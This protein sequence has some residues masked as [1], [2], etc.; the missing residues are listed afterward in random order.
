M[1][2]DTLKKKV[3]DVI[4]AKSDAI[5]KIGE[6]V[7]D[8]PEMGYREEKT[9]KLVRDTFDELGISYTYPVA[10]TGVKGKL[11]GKES[12]YNVCIMSEEDCIK[13]AENPHS[14][15]DGNSHACG[16]HAQIAAMLGAAIGIKES[17]VMDELYGDIT[18]MATPAEE[19]IELDYR[20]LLKDEG[21][22]Q[23]Y[24]GKQQLIYEGAF[25]DVDMAMMIHAQGND[26]GSKFYAKGY[27][28]GFMAST[29]TFKGKAV[30]ASTPFDGVNALNAASLAILGV[31]SN[32]E[33]F[34][35]EDRIRIH[36]IITKGGDVVNAVP[37]E[38][39]VDTYV[40][41]ASLDAINK[42]FDALIRACN[43]AAQMVGATVEFLNVPGYLPLKESEELSA[44]M[45][46]NAKAILGEDKIIYGKEITGSTD[47]GDLSSILPTIQPSISGFSG[48]LHSKEFDTV[49]K[50][51]AYITSA[52]LLAATAIDL[53]FDGAKG[54]KAVVDNF[55][56][57][58]SKE[59]YLEYLG[60]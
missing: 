42:G 4:D 32:R 12:R 25:D 52:K 45:E 21:K 17:G 56:G 13:C 60:K 55:K 3:F 8:N 58:M 15:T 29:I 49:D 40:R 10:Y 24:G 23:Y 51:S 9:A 41:G 11:K 1:N 34:R 43:G 46:D 39:C 18:F 19:F 16:H 22:I 59:E 26:T 5:I 35:E 33:T 50:V 27:N 36:P 31:H 6:M 53:L 47:A 7:R 14:D 20:K 57:V 54:A 38:V 44:V 30:H 28:L 48:T 37:D 2:V